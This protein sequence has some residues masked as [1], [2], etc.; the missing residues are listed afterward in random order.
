MKVLTV[1]LKPTNYCNVGCEH[2]YLTEEVRANKTKLD[3][4]SLE[5]AAM[6]IKELKERENKTHVSIIWHG[7]EPLTLPAHYFF[8]AGEILDKHLPN[9]VESI[10]TSL[11]PLRE[12]HIPLIQQRFDYQVGSSIDFTQRKVK[13]SIDNYQTLWLKKVSL[14]RANGIY[15]IPGIVPTRNE[16]DRAG[17]IIDWLCKNGFDRVNFERYNKYGL[18]G[19]PVDWPNNALHSQFLISLFDET[20]SRVKEERPYVFIKQLSAAIHG[21]VFAQPGDR[22][23]GGCQ[24]DFIVIEPDL[25]TN[26]CPDRTSRDASFS[27]IN[28]GVVNFIN[29]K[30]RKKWI[31]HQEIGHKTPNCLTCEF[32]PWCRSGCPITPKLSGGE[33]SGYKRFLLHVKNF[34]ST[35]SDNER[36][37]MDYSME[38]KH[39]KVSA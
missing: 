36:L 11:I 21:V 2:C 19:Q 37:A 22:W 13:G 29:S 25:S 34:I 12:E 39:K 35:S 5:K 15:V 24:R 1:Y 14:A 9:H 30:E 28:D 7:G 4:L 32:R 31:R 23:G 38:R 16:I 26:S 6:F 20:I 27:N 3:S 10:Q 17:Y 33:C 18:P 8:E